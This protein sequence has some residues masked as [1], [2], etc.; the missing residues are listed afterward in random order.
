ME[1]L[2]TVD[3][4]APQV[5]MTKQALYAAIR[6]KKFPAIHIGKRI[7]ISGSVLRRWIE[8]GGTA[9]SD[10]AETN[11]AKKEVGNEIED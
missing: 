1:P 11:P 10:I 7:R 3:E 4:I 9:E 8:S 5:K 6:E 2:F